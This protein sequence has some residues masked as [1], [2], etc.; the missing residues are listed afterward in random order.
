MNTLLKPASN[1]L[2][3]WIS[4]PW[5]EF[6]EICD[7]PDSAKCKSY[8]YKQQMRFEDI[9]TGSDHAKVHMTVIMSVGL[10]ASIQGIPLNGHDCCSY[11]QSG[12]T[13]FQPD[14]SY[15][16]GD[17][18]DAIAW[19]T[20]I[21]DLEQYPL[22]DLVIEISD[23][24]FNDDLGTKRLQYEELGIKEYWIVNVQTMKI[25]VFAIAPDGSSHHIRQSLVLSGLKLEILEQALERSRQANQSTVTAWLMQQFQG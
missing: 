20:R 14:V 4:A 6:V 23:T 11:R 8:Y 12:K 7:A 21:I 25:Y 3:T 15:Y 17:N 16:I 5:T 24:T 9:S 1:H 22:P 13:E 19:G 18:A 2:N 10:F